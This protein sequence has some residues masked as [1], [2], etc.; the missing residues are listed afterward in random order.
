M[1]RP[2]KTINPKQL[3]TLASIQC[4]LVEI[5]AVMGCSKRTLQRNYRK[6]I[7]AGRKKGRASVRR[8]QWKLLQG[9]NATMAIWLGK[10]LL[11]QTDK[12][13]MEHTG[14]DG[15]PIKTENK[16]NY[17]FSG[18]SDEELLKLERAAAS[19]RVGNG[20]ASRN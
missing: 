5:A 11:G 2:R 8:A 16:T 1:A 4:T 14:K 13:A 17:D 15:G 12:A 6:V 19:G 10:Q 9:G 3:E 7:L 20:Q 18:W